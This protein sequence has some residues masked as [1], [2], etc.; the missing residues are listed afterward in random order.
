VAA[1]WQSVGGGGLEQ[2]RVL[3]SVLETDC[4]LDSA[5]TRLD[6]SAAA[7]LVLD[8]LRYSN[9][10]PIGS[11]HHSRGSRWLDTIRGGRPRH[12]GLTSVS[13]PLGRLELSSAG[14]GCVWSVVVVCQTRLDFASR[15]TFRSCVALFFGNATTKLLLAAR[16]VVVVVRS[17]AG[18]GERR[19][20]KGRP[21]C[22][23]DASDLR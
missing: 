19:K 10:F 22:E 17:S 3:L 14:C 21:V 18:G 7:G 16:R 9:L 1:A 2:C 15:A 6:C 8:N 5:E 12:L 11:G 13:S 4:L 20:A 23:S